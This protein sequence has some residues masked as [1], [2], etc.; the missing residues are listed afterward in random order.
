MHPLFGL[1]YFSTVDHW[2]DAQALTLVGVTVGL[3]GSYL[4]ASSLFGVGMHAMPVDP[5]VALRYE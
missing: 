5:I 1:R 2:P 4:L 3:A